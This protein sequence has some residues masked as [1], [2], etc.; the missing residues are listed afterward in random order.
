MTPDMKRYETYLQRLYKNRQESPETEMLGQATKRFTEPFSIINKKLQATLNMDKASVGAKIMASLQGQQQIQGMAE[1]MSDKAV[2]MR[3]ERIGKID[4]SIAQTEANMAAERERE[5]QEKAAKNTSTLRAGL[6]AAGF[7]AAALLAIPTG[8]IT[9]AAI[10]AIAGAGA[11][12]GL[13]G[14]F[15]GGFVGINKGGHLSAD[16]DEW[17][18]QATVGA[19]QEAG[20]IGTQMAV[21]ANMKKNLATM[22]ATMPVIGSMIEKMNEKQAPIFAFGLKNAILYGDEPTIKDYLFSWQKQIGALENGVEPESNYWD[23]MR[24]PVGENDNEYNYRKGGGL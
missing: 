3:S 22:S 17:D 12:G 2:T 16:P 13:A 9:L 8:G 10:P 24:S 20:Q 18:M 6:T 23:I 15:A 11:L 7:I 5:K 4:E 19:L 21:D 1:N 14:Q